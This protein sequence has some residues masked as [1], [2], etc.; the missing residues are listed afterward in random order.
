MWGNFFPIGIENLNKNLK[1]TFKIL[2]NR[3]LYYLARISLI[4]YLARK[5]GMVMRTEEAVVIRL[6][7]CNLNLKGGNYASHKP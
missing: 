1:E 2:K 7:G 6:Q 4:R 3:A 5:Q